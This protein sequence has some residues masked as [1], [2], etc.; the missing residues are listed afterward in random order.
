MQS[1]IELGQ[2]AINNKL[3]LLFLPTRTYSHCCYISK[4]IA[5]NFNKTIFKSNVCISLKTIDARSFSLT[6]VCAKGKDR[7][8][9][10]KKSKKPQ[11]IDLSQVSEVTNVDQMTLEMERAIEH[12]KD[13]FIKH[14]SVR[15]TTGSIE[16][17]PVTYEGK[18]YKI[19]ELAQIVRKPKL[20]VLNIS[21]LPQT[22]PQIIVALSKSGMNLNPQQDGTTLYI[23]IPK[24]TKEHREN[25]SKSARTMYIKCRDNIKDVQN[26]YIKEAK[27]KTNVSEDL[28][29]NAQ[30]Q[31]QAQANKFIMDAEKILETKQ[32]ELLASSD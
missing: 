29:R 32:K 19:Q 10:K 5:F 7:G 14:L 30:N 6:A 11:H 8:G 1:L 16:L 21:S 26:K 27:R 22:I 23:P 17:I 15:S 9:E 25:L 24:V 2:R 18:E 12:L 4:T 28:I 31:I 13:N 3:F 20:V